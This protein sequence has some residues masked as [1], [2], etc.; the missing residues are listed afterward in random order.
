MTYS[1]QSRQGLERRIRLHPRIIDQE[2]KAPARSA[3]YHLPTDWHV[4]LLD[5]QA[6]Q[7][8]TADDIREQADH[9]IVAHSHVGHDLLERNLFGRIVLVLLTTTAEFLAQLCDFSLR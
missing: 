6:G 5:L 7:V 2:Q 1:N 8:H 9:I 3:L 4:H